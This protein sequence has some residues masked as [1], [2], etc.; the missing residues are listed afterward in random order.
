MDTTLW[1]LLAFV[2]LFAAA[3]FGAAWVFFEVADGVLRWYDVPLT[4]WSVLVVIGTGF[5]A[6]GYANS[7]DGQGHYVAPPP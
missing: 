1:S 5:C 6:W 4:A 3:T 2:A 7:G